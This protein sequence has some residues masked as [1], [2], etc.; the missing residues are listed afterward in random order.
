MKFVE[1]CSNHEKS[2]TYSNDILY[3]I[4]RISSCD[5]SRVFRIKANKISGFVNKELFIDESTNLIS[6][7]TKHPTSITRTDSPNII[8]DIIRICLAFL[9]IRTVFNKL[10]ATNFNKQQ[11]GKSFVV[12]M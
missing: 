5:G 10:L 8:Q 11:K 1:N 4:G 3:D 9:M 12:G 6:L 7:Y 2:K